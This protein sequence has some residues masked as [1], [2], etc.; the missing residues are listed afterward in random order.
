VRREDPD[1]AHAAPAAG[2]GSPGYGWE[3]GGGGG[4][5]PL[6]LL[7][8]W[9]WTEVED[10][11]MGRVGFISR[12]WEAWRPKFS[13][14]QASGPCGPSASPLW[15]FPFFFPFFYRFWICKLWKK[16]TNPELLRS[17]TLHP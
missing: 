13:S 2:H 16:S 10:D 1:G 12:V 5:V 11:L 8:R 3:G 4:A 9:T 17:E 15:E 7:L 14:I 6:T